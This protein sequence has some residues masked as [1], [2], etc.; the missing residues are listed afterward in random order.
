[1]K[2]FQLIDHIQTEIVVIDKNMTIV[3]ANNAFQHRHNQK[4]TNVIGTK[5]F[6]AAYKFAEGCGYKEA[7]SCPVRRS[8]LSKKPASAIHHFW[9]E[10]HAVVEELTTTPI[11]E[12]NGDVNFVIEE[13]RDITQLLGLKKGIIGI[14]SYCRKIRDEGGQWITF[15]A[16][17]HKHTGANF[18]HGICEECNENLFSDLNTET[19]CSHQAKVKR[20]R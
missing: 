1:M 16:Y 12:D 11:I 3:D 2:D 9:I 14:C 17:L 8:F 5:C 19:S 7:G 15:E 6:N 20:D 13:Y 10:D 18:S 4:C